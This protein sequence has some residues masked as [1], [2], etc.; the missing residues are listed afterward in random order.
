MSDGK[1]FILGSIGKVG[2]FFSTEYG[3]TIGAA[4][5]LFVGPALSILTKA[6]QPALIGWF[7]EAAQNARANHTT[8]LGSVFSSLKFSVG[9][10]GQQIKG[11]WTPI[12]EFFTVTLPAVFGSGGS[13]TLGEG[14]T[15]FL[16]DMG[17]ALSA[18][19][20]IVWVAIAAVTSLSSAYGGIGGVLKRIGQIF[21]D[22]A[23]HVKEFADRIGFSE[24]LQVLAKGFGTIYDALGRLKPLWE[25]VFTTL[26]GVATVAIEA[27][28]GL[29]GGLAEMLGGVAEVIGGVIGIIVDLVTLNFDN[30]AADIESI[31]NGIKDFFKGCLDAIVGFVS[32]FVDG[33]IQWFL[34]LKYNLIGDPIVIDM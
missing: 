6:Y 19:N 27:L 29:F 31:W 16:T 18:V 32:G 5:A 22:T 11:L 15:A 12:K 26:T 33:I 25:I 30:L 10:F 4:I 2:S 8:F 21:S 20:P 7:T 9:K 34:D 24:K 14:I 28:V 23:K 1:N 13:Y 17:K 3:P